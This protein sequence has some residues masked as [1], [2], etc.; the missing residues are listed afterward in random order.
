MTYVVFRREF[1]EVFEKRQARLA[2][3]EAGLLEV[4]PTALA[5]PRRLQL[6]RAALR[7][8]LVDLSVLKGR[9]EAVETLRRFRGEG[10][11]GGGA[12]V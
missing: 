7:S 4:V 3:L 5:E 2:A 12:G 10:D 9:R 1:V 6:V 8:T 11:G